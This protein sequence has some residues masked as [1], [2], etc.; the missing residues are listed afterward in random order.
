MLLQ[1][2]ARHWSNPSRRNGSYCYSPPDLCFLIALMTHSN[3]FV[4]EFVLFVDYVWSYD[5]IVGGLV[6]YVHDAISL[7]AGNVSSL[8]SA[9]VSLQRSA[10]CMSSMHNYSLP[11]E[12]KA[13]ELLPKCLSGTVSPVQYMLG[14]TWNQVKL[15]PYKYILTL[16]CSTEL[17]ISILIF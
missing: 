14:T 3:Y 11:A 10:P 5:L 2:F 17:K 12:N 4:W 15:I 8:L 1:G 6:L 13:L 9:Q 7:L 16:N